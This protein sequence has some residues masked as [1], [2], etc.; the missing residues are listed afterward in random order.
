M[1]KGIE[2]VVDNE[3][4]TSGQS[5]KDNLLPPHSISNRPFDSGNDFIFWLQ[6]VL[7]RVIS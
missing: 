2:I 3:D 7:T 4:K 6:Y 1:L 5:N